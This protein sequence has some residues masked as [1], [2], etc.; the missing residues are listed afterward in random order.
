[1]KYGFSVI[2]IAVIFSST[3]GFA[4][5]LAKDFAKKEENNRQAACLQ[6]AASQAAR[7]LK[8]EYNVVITKFDGVDYS[9]KTCTGSSE[10]YF[11]VGKIIC[12]VNA[13]YNLDFT[14]DS[15]VRCILD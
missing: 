11:S 10:I 15:Q 13:P 3:S 1:M 2:M 6:K 8:N 12:Q 4:G 14:H 9:H 7:V 5:N